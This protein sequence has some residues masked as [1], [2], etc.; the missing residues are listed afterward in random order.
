M[1]CKIIIFFDFFL[2]I[3]NALLISILVEAPVDSITGFLVL[4]I[5]FINGRFVI[6]DDEILK[7]FTLVLKKSIVSVSNGVIIKSILIFL[8]YWTIFS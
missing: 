5:F 7:Y 1:Q 3:L 8:Q 6:S 4:A 2:K